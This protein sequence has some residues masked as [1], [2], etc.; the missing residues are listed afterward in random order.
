MGKRGPKP[1][2]VKKPEGSGRR[3]GTPNKR[4]EELIQR[5]E[6]KGAAMPADILLDIAQSHYRA[7]LDLGKPDGPVS[8]QARLAA[9][10]AAPYYHAT[11]KSIEASGPDGGAFIVEHIRREIVRPADHA[12]DPDS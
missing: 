2:T 11:L 1:G 7:W 8:D 10:D 4:T 6:A 3:A 5:A 9:K 12:D